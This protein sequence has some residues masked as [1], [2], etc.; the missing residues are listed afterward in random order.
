MSITNEFFQN[1]F[2]TLSTSIKMWHPPMIPIWYQ[3][4]ITSWSCSSSSRNLEVQAR[5][6]QIKD[7]IKR[8]AAFTNNVEDFE[9][10]LKEHLGWANG[11]D[12]PDRGLLWLLIEPDLGDQLEG[13]F[14]AGINITLQEH[15]S[16]HCYVSIEA[17]IEE[18]SMASMASWTIARSMGRV[19][20]V[21]GLHCVAALKR[22]L[23]SRL[24]FLRS[25]QNNDFYKN[26]R[27]F[28]EEVEIF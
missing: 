27:F 3:L 4:D 9:N 19:E 11:G 18:A 7:A 24:R 1:K 13:V 17:R 20:D 15:T 10:A 26:V 6:A 8:V 14:P 28:S 12:T 23:K 2:A 21:E 16:H 25:Q 5:K 22:V